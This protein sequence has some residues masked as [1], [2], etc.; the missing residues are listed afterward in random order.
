MSYK[1]LF[2]S[3]M[4]NWA[5]ELRKPDHQP[6]LNT[7]VSYEKISDLASTQLGPVSQS[8]NR[9]KSEF[10]LAK[11]LRV[12]PGVTSIKQVGKPGRFDATT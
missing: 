4:K 8:V 12:F 9:L 7:G 1:E 6:F 11:I 3:C 10:F 5:T 2:F